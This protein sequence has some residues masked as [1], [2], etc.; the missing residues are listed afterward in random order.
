MQQKKNNPVNPHNSLV[1]I[2]QRHA[3]MGTHVHRELGRY[4]NSITCCGQFHHSLVQG[5]RVSGG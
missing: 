1:G 5:M 3:L 2:E 4:G